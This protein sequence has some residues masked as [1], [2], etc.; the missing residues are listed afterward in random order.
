MKKQILLI[1]TFFLININILY[2][3][4]LAS[5]L[6][7]KVI[8]RNLS[9][10]EVIMKESDGS[11]LDMTDITNEGSYNLD[12]TIMDTP[13]RTEVDKLILEIKNKSG[14]NKKVNVK[15]YMKYFDETVEL[16]PII[17]N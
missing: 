13:S 7:G 11:I 15:D 9:D 14:F 12:L 10:I 2:A 4:K 17:L 5:V 6:K 16:T 8:S 1:L 3:E